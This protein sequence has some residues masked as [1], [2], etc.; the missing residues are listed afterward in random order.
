[1]KEVEGSAG[2][3]LPLWPTIRLSYTSYFRHFGDVLRISALWL[4]LMAVLNAGI[5]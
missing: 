2:A 1:M 4:S 3:K 5:S